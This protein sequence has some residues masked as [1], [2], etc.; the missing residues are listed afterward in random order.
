[1]YIRPSGRVSV[2]RNYS[3]NLFSEPP[4]EMEAEAEV[5]E[6]EIEEKKEEVEVAPVISQTKDIFSNL[7]GNE[8]LIILGLILLLSQDGFGDDIIPILLLILFF[9]K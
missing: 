5:L 2:P 3:G 1:M 4:P 6:D 7:F 8:D 9:K